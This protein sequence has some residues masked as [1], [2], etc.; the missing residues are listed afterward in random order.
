MGFTSNY[1]RCE[2][3]ELHYTEW[4]LRNGRING[5]VIAWHGFVGTCREMDDLAGHLSQRYR[6]VCPDT[7]G[8]G[9]SEWSSDP[10]RE[11]TLSFYVRLAVSL[12]DQL[13][14]DRLHW[15]GTSMGAA[16]GMLAAATRLRGRV[17]RLVLNDVGPQLLPHVLE[18]VHRDRTT[19]PTFLRASELESY[20]REGSAGTFDANWR[21]KAQSTMRRLPDGRITMHYDPEVAVHH[22]INE[23]QE[24]WPAWERLAVPVLCVRGPHQNPQLQRTDELLRGTGPHA[25]VVEVPGCHAAPGLNTPDQFA[26][27]DR[28]LAGD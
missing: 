21:L 19:L 28:F 18:R 12:V 22:S 11:Y 26:L 24:L 25:V 7:I 14:I 4:G 5:T 15:I 17:K 1:I 3:R 10:T 9:L 6:V 2:G 27:V 8:R 16:V 23:P 20:I 13:G